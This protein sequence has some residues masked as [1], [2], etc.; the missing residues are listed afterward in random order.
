MHGLRAGPVASAGTGAA[1][2][3]A[4]ELLVVAIESL[5]A[6]LDAEFG[7]AAAFLAAGTVFT[8]GGKELVAELIA[9]LCC[10]QTRLRIVRDGRVGQSDES[11]RDDQK[12]AIHR[13][14]DRAL[15]ASAQE[16]A[17]GVP[18]R[19]RI[20]PVAGDSHTV[21]VVSRRIARVW[22]VELMERTA[23]AAVRQAAV[24]CRSVQAALVDGTTLEKRDKS[25]VTV[26][27]FAS[28]AVVSAL[29]HQHLAGT[30][31]VAEEDAEE[32]R[33]AEN[34]NLRNLVVTQVRSVLGT[35]VEPAAVVDWIDRGRAEPD[36]CYW[37]LDPIDGTKG[38]LRGGQYA[39][40]LALIEEGEVA[41]GVLGC[42]NLPSGGDRSSA[43]GALFVAHRGAPARQLDLWDESDFTG[44]AV[45]VAAI[46]D[47]RQARFCESV[48]AG[49]SDQDESAEIASRLGI[50][51]APYRIDS[52]CKYAC[53]A[54]A[55]ASIYLRLPTRA[56]YREKIWDHAAGKL[57]VEAA[58][59]RVTDVDGRP[60][61]FSRGRSL[62]ENRGIIATCGRI[63]DRVL[64]VVR[65]VHGG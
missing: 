19:N 40:A 35:D 41:F 50:T 47:A 34:E 43:P 25:P 21:L 30:V 11:E 60:L 44:T 56:D 32:L 64:E 42:P 53:V 14:E 8:V 36:G 65:E 54:R 28:Q 13:E 31:L 62:D 52:Q 4:I 2:S 58:G 3:A 63:H 1:V 12:C 5:R 9:L 49:H 7:L 48:E 39:I 23:L 17:W 29:L 37:T 59:G 6:A 38:Y 20:L 33:R 51:A 61:A 46:D 18:C 22:E 57:L 24:V 15:R 27:D 16:A 26:A 55:D 45:R 10:G